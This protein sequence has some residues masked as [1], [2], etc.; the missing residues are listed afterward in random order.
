MTSPI[1]RT[2]Q[3][4][5][6]IGDRILCDQL[7]LSVAAGQ[8]MAV[9]GQNGS[10]KTTLLHS[11]LKLCRVDKS[12][13]EIDGR[14]LT[15]WSRRDLAK[16][17]GILFQEN[18]DDMPATVHETVMLGRLPHLSGWRWESESDFALAEN[19]LKT[20]GLEA[21]TGRNVSSLSGGERQRLAIA[22]LLTQS[23]KLYLLDEPSN[24]LDI[25]FQIKTLKLLTETVIRDNSALIMA[26]HDINLAARFCDQI[27]LLNG[28]GTYTLGPAT[29][30]LTDVTL[31]HAYNCEIRHVATDIGKLYFPVT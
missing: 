17:V 15:H 31:S 13:I 22:S 11:L 18:Q 12:R 16:T 14:A 24:H 29:E 9:L 19:A 1:V 23:P 2:R 8:R 6:Q 28:D 7:N 4:R 30:V 27:L 5:L 3:L 25:S 21:M 26:T 20:V 10:G